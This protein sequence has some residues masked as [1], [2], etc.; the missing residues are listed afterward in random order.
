MVSYQTKH[1]RKEAR[2]LHLHHHHRQMH[3]LNI[4]AGVPK[5]QIANQIVVV[6]PDTATQSIKFGCVAFG[7]SESYPLELQRRQGVKLRRRSHSISPTEMCLIQA[8]VRRDNLLSYELNS[9]SVF[10]NYRPS[11]RYYMFKFQPKQVYFYRT[12]K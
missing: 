8:F 5:Y 11:W 4:T 6:V 12:S 7:P 3:H 10:L 1:E 2:H 9:V